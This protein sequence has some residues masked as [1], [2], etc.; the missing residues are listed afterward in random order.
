MM[1]KSYGNSVETGEVITKLGADSFRQWAASGGAT[2]YDIP[3]RWNEAEYGKKFLTKLW[4]IARFTIAS[5]RSAPHPSNFYRLPSIDQWLLGSL[6]VLVETVTTAFE[7]FQFNTA[8]EAIR[9]FTWH[10]LADDY[11][12][13]VK[14]RL[15]P[16]WAGPD[17]ESAR[18]CLNNALLTIC[19][20]IAPICPHIAEAIYQEATP[21]PAENSVHSEKW[22]EPDLTGLDPNRVNDGKLIIETIAKARRRKSEKGLSLKSPITKIVI[23]TVEANKNRLQENQEPILRTIKSQSLAFEMA[24]EGQ[25]DESTVQVEI[26]V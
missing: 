23:M 6:R 9:E 13:S 3:F 18:F 15:Q 7:N 2:G 22:P 11:I 24:P 19:K 8:L 10:S 25:D 16:D 12:E 14:Y 5:S 26:V 4:N 21:R 17:A 1:H 20:L